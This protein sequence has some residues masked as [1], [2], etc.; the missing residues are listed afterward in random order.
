MSSPYEDNVDKIIAERKEQL[1]ELEEQIPKSKGLFAKRRLERK[2]RQYKA[3]IAYLEADV[4]RYR[5]AMDWLRRKGEFSPKA[6]AEHAAHP[7]DQP[8]ENK[9]SK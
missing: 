5:R 1:K 9:N 2:I 3:D 7:V 8:A 6:M 4:A